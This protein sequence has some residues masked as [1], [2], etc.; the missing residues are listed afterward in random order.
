MPSA[1]VTARDM[2]LIPT[3]A[4][5]MTMKIKVPHLA[6]WGAFTA[7]SENDRLIGCEPFCRRRSVAHAQHHS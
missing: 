7:V 1:T 4:E 2:L 5:A 3:P 6:H